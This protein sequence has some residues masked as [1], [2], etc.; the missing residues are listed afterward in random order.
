MVERMSALPAYV[1]PSR[2][3]AG[4]AELVGALVAARAGHDI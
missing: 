4:F 3:G 2:G 1:T